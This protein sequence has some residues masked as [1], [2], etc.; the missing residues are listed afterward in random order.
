MARAR[1]WLDAPIPDSRRCL[2]L[3]MCLTEGHYSPGQWLQARSSYVGTAVCT[4]VC[5]EIVL[6]SRAQLTVL[7]F[8]AGCNWYGWLE[9]ELLKLGM[10]VLIQDMPDPYVAKE[11]VW[12]PFVKTT[13]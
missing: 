6:I 12:I 4:S 5:A 8:P 1:H 3:C 9:S 11:S 10:E 7:L 2:C 13:V